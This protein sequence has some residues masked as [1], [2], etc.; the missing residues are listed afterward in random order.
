[1]KEP[2]GLVNLDMVGAV[3]L[4]SSTEERA[5]EVVVDSSAGFGCG[6]LRYERGVLS[7]TAMNAWINQPNL[8][9]ERNITYHESFNSWISL[10][11]IL[12]RV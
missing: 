9:L 12:L 8:S 6:M 11:D 1:M 2:A 10:L 4:A 5:G 7:L 3:S